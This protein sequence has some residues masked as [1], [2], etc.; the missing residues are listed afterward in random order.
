M[1]PTNQLHRHLELI[2][3]LG[4]GVGGTVG[5]GIFVLVGQ[6]AA[7]YAGRACGMSFAIA[8][9]A[10]TLSGACY[11]ELSS[12][13]PAAG[14]TYVY[15]YVCLG[16]WAA[17]VAAACLTLEYGV[18]GAA[19]ARTWGDKVLLMLLRTTT[20]SDNHND[21]DLQPSATMFSWLWQ[22]GGMINLP[23]GLISA[24]STALLLSGVQ[25]SKTVLNW[26]TL[27]KM[28]VVLFMILG[29]FLL[30]NGTE[31]AATTPWAPWGGTGVL[32]GATT[33]FFGYLGYDEICC[34]A[35]EAKHPARDLPRAVLGTL[36]IVTVCY[37]LAA[38]ALTGMLPYDQL[39][40]TAGFPDAFAV[41]GYAGMAALTAWGEILSLPVVV[42]ISLLAQPRLTL[43]MAVDGL[44]PHRWFASV[45]ASGNLFQGTLVSGAAMTVIA[46]TVPFTYLDDLISAGILLAFSMTNSCLVLLRCQS[47]LHRP[48]LLERL[49]GLYNALCFTTALLWSHTGNTAWHLQRGLAVLS[50]LATV[51]CFWYIAWHCP[52][53][54]HF[55]GSILSPGEYARERHI[56]H[57]GSIRNDST[58]TNER[59][60]NDDDNDDTEDTFENEN[61]NTVSYFATPAVPMLP[62]LG[63][64][65]NWYL[66]A[67]LE[68]SGLA[69]LVLYLSLTTALYLTKCAPHSV[70]HNQNWSDH[71]NYETVQTTTLPVSSC[72]SR[73]NSKAST[74][75]PLRDP[76][77]PYN[78]DS[79]DTIAMFP[80]PAGKRKPTMTRTNSL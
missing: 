49:L 48:Y 74:A 39:S 40:A 58:D 64:A 8:G 23:A 6:I 11:A 28:V 60:T 50:S 26:V 29:G 76:C 55:G 56:T 45:D 19:V 24:M 10:A 13:I 54:A 61:E 22:P 51:V 53:T 17:T 25:E 35:G 37:I 30:Y 1:P 34:V 70:G 79:D 2:D 4:I 44:L 43:S 75:A 15:A 65:V 14:S 57:E 78:N 27:F 63:M 77:R 59:A 16:E 3:L 18:A 52:K 72:H 32:R 33:S 12:R 69:L 73:I 41:R 67:Q 46:T 5:S 31:I 47:P 68:W 71:H 80:D 20:S 21:D 36:A 62:C 42:L 7:Q 9:A 38:Q 66:I